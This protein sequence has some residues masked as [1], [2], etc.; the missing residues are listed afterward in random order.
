ML[1]L[2][3]SEI[4][5]VLELVDIAAAAHR[6]VG[7]YSLGMRQRIGLARAVLGRP[8]L[9]VL[10]EPMNGLDP[11]GVRELRAVIRSLPERTGA[12][13]LLSSHMLSEI[14]QA[15]THVGVMRE[16]RLVLQGTVEDLFA[17]AG[18]DLVVRVDRAD[19]AAGLLTREGHAVRSEDGALHVASVRD[20]RTRPP[21]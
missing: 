15:V 21:R 1:G 5:R 16:G 8:R 10:D 14:E 2:P 6:K 3:R 12:T 20:D 17:R 18:Q 11:D 13:V 7:Q 4:G 9:L 19:E